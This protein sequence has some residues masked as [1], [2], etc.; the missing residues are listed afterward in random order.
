MIQLPVEPYYINAAN[1]WLNNRNNNNLQFQSWLESQ[2]IIV[3]ERKEYY[4][5]LDFENP[6]LAT[7]FRIKWATVVF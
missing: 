4:P 3:K 6:L 7:L 5:W 1:W 2:G